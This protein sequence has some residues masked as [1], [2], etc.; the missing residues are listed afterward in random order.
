MPRTASAARRWRADASALASAAFLLSSPAL[1]ERWRA[2]ISSRTIPRARMT[3]SHAAS[4]IWLSPARV[5]ARLNIRSSADGER[6]GI[7]QRLALGKCANGEPQVLP[8]ERFRTRCH[9]ERLDRRSSVG[10]ELGEAASE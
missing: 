9:R 10:S 6:R 5:E 1:A 4:A 8:T 3:A 7:C 2:A